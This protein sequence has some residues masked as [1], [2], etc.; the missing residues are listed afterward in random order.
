MTEDTKAFGGDSNDARQRLNR[1]NA[2]MLGLDRIEAGRL[3]LNICPLD[4][5][6]ILTEA[7]DRARSVSPKHTIEANLDPALPAVHGDSDRL[8]QVVA[9]LLSNAVKY[10]PNGGEN[11]VRGRANAPQAAD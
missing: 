1:M 9:N 5:N 4:I 2:G 8:F 3:T 6:L 10:S 7:A 11:L